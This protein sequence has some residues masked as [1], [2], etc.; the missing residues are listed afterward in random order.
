MG[1]L[2]RKLPGAGPKASSSDAEGKL[3]SKEWRQRACCT[4]R[5]ITGEMVVDRLPPKVPG[6]KVLLR[7]SRLQGSLTDREISSALFDR[8]MT[9]QELSLLRKGIGNGN[10]RL[11]IGP[12]GNDSEPQQV[13]TS[14]LF[15]SQVEGRQRLSR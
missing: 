15:H 3:S 10:S 5:L 8:R 11:S 2:G 12:W 9:T 7:G 6:L 4:S 13:L 1:E 14:N